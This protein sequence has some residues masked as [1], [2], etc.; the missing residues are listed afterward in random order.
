[1]VVG[2]SFLYILFYFT[3]GRCTY[4]SFDL[5]SVLIAEQVYSNSLFATLNARNMIREAG[6]STDDLSL[7]LRDL[8][9]SQVPNFL[10]NLDFD[11]FSLPG[12]IEEANTG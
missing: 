11:F 12:D 3:L 10:L 7:S 6:D 1:V 9:L 8:A 4:S 2:T 5:C